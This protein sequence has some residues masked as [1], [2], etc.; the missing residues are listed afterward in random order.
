MGVTSL[1][2][3]KSSMEN[4]GRRTGRVQGRPFP[5]SIFQSRSLHR[6]HPRSLTLHA[7]DL[8]VHQGIGRPARAPDSRPPARGRLGPLLRP[9]EGLPTG[10][11]V[12]MP[13]P[14]TFAAPLRLCACL[15]ENFMRERHGFVIRHRLRRAPRVFLPLGRYFPPP[16]GRGPPWHPVPALNLPSAAGKRRST[17]PRAE[18]RKTC[19]LAGRGV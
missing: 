10:A 13:L 8:A 11:M 3:L 12:I 19:S 7:E 6:L 14:L 2:P 17:L 1:C 16:C 18:S 15:K 4:V 9:Q 5:F